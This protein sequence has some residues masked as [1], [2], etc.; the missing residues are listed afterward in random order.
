MRIC[1]LVWLR[2][3]GPSAVLAEKAGHCLGAFITSSDN[4]IFLQARPA[5]RTLRNARVLGGSTGG[6]QINLNK[7]CV[8]L[9][10][11][12]QAAKSSVRRD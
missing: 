6:T 10:D 9:S 4:L 3:I 7:L 5:L 12:A 8:R 11:V 1:K 2:C